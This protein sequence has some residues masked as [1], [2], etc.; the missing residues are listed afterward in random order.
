MPEYNSS[1]LKGKDVNSIYTFNDL[2]FIIDL[3][4]SLAVESG[5][6]DLNANKET[7][8]KLEI[9]LKQ[10]DNIPLALLQDKSLKQEIYRYKQNIEF[11]LKRYKFPSQWSGFNLEDETITQELCDKI[12]EAGREIAK[13]ISPE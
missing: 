2:R 4:R 13:S 7:K 11:R 3:Y 5:R 6:I 1:S 9:L 8:N 10:I 12:N